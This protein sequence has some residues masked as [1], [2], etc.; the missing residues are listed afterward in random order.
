MSSIPCRTR[1]LRGS[2]R[3]RAALVAAAV[4]LLSARGLAD[5]PED[6]AQAVIDALRG[7]K[8]AAVLATLEPEAATKEIG[9]RPALAHVILD[10][11]YR[12]DGQLVAAVEERR[13]LAE[14]LGKLA[15]TAHAAHPEDDRTRWALALSLVLRERAG[16]RTGAEAWTR[17]AD[18]LVDV[19]GRTPGEGE[20]LAYALSFLLEGACA[21]ESARH[22]L[23]KRADT[24]A[25]RA[26]RR[27][28]ESA[29]LAQTLAASY[30][31]AART[32]APQQRKASKQALRYALDLLR[33]H[34]RVETPDLEPASLFNDA[35]TFGKTS[36]FVMREAYV[37]LPAQALEGA[38]VFDVPVSKHW[39]V[40]DVPSTEETPGYVYV[41]ET[42]AAGSRVRQL[43]FRRYFWG[44]EYA[45]GDSGTV[46]GDNVKKIVR[47][48]Q[49]L[50]AETTF[51]PG[52]RTPKIAKHKL[53][54]DLAG[55]A[56]KIRGKT[57]GE[58]PEPLCV[59]G[60]GVRG[61]HQATLVVLVYVYDG[62]ESLGPELEALLE[63][64]R[65]PEE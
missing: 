5:G 39:F 40:R 59:L 64:L 25:R 43:L 52:A 3:C 17:A 27:H 42:D 28:R 60:H 34:V 30:L 41:T 51:A 2:R 15:E 4:L 12:L 11:A 24:L 36:K 9:A 7:G 58:S 33:P 62:T 61:S 47:G 21:D 18:L 26:L 14:R 53:T 22:K 46:K 31:W 29:A 54:R 32:L 57:R 13:A 20:A 10:R 1:P 35:V 55:H 65:E 23:Q 38:L 8:T 45:F 44:S 19:Y 6:R 63:S 16:P 50:A 56:F 37:T 48:L 49:G